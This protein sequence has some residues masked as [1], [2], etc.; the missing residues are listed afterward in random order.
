MQIKEI[1]IGDYEELIR[2]W[3]VNYFVNEVDSFD[4]FQ[5]FLDKNP[6]LSFLMEDNG[7][8]IGTVLGSF[9]GRRGYIQ[10]LV[11]DK[12]Y[13]GKGIGKRL[14]EKAIKKLKELGTLYIPINC[15]A[16]NIGFYEKVGFKKSNQT[17]MNISNSTYSY[18]K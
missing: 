1:L 8:I 4:R 15:E 9:D 17:P 2:F 13:R 18:K 12:N 3:K 16:E 14:I 7:Q 11:V 10:K 5:L 6:H